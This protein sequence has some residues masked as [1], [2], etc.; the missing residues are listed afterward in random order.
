MIS[1]LVESVERVVESEPRE[2]LAYEAPFLTE[3]LMK[4]NIVES[5]EEATLL[6][7]EAKRYFVLVHEDYPKLWEMYSLRI[8]EVW[9]QFVLFTNEYMKFCRRYFGRYL[10]HAPSNAPIPEEVAAM[11]VGTFEDFRARYEELFGEALPDVWYDERSITVNRRVVNDFVN[12]WTFRGDGDTIDMLT[13]EGNVLISVNEF[14]GEALAFA[15]GTG[16]YYVRELP[17][18]LDDDEKTAL[19]ST[20][21]A[22]NL[23]RVAP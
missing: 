14:A 11:R 20:L 13:P 16:A 15:V 1:D 22:C 17:G 6:F 10:P 21:V 19:V 4:E 9:H 5:V 7:R 23:L 3:K 8:D 2:A 18:G 12:A